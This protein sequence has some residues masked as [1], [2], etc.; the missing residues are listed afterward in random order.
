MI[1]KENKMGYELVVIW[2]NGD[3]DV[4]EYDSRD[5]AEQSGDGMKTA[6][7]NQIAW[8]GVRPV[9]NKEA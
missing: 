1:R 4:Y 7:G 6:L 8:Y 5:R 2:E 3:N 9:T